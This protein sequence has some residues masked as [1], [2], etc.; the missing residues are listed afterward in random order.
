MPLLGYYP[1][2]P[3]SDN[4]DSAPT[5]PIFDALKSC[6]VPHNLKGPWKVSSTGS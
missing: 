6:F 2:T 5:L 3:A 1:Q 4:Y